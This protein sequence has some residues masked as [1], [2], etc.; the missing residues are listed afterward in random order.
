MLAAA[1]VAAERGLPVSLGDVDVK[2]FTPRLRGLFAE[3]LRDLLSPP[4]GWRRIF[5]DLK[6]GAGLAFDV[7]DLGGESLGFEDF[8]RPGLLFGL[9]GSFLRYPAAAAVKAP[10]PF[11]ALATLLTVGGSTIPRI[12]VRDSITATL[13]PGPRSSRKRCANWMAAACGVW[14]PSRQPMLLDPSITI[15]TSRRDVSTSPRNSESHAHANRPPHY[16][17]IGEA[18]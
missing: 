4:D 13:S 7:S 12:P 18:G 1:D 15:T 16:T 3:S 5:D 17:G 10:A 14:C 8:L 6:R 11:F 2:E 9:A